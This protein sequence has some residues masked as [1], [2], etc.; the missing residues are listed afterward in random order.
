VGTA[1]IGYDH[2]D[3][4]YLRKKKI[5]FAS[6]PGSNANSVSEYITASLLLLAR[7][8]G[9]K[10][11]GSTIAVV[12]VGN[13]GSLVVKKAKTLGMNCLLNDP[14]KQ[15]QSRSGEYAPLKEAL[16]L[17]DYV[18]L[19]VPMQKKGKYATYQMAD[20]KFFLS[21]KKEASF[22]NSSRGEVVV[23]KDLKNALENGSLRDVVMDVWQNEPDIDPEMVEKTFIATPH[24]A[25]YSFDG[26]VN[27][28]LMMFNA[29]KKHLNSHAEFTVENLLPP[30]Y[31]PEI[32]LAEKK[33]ND[34]DILLD[35]ILEVYDIRRDD[36]EMRKAAAKEN[37]R[38]LEFD[39]LRKE[40]PRRREFQ[41][42][43]LFFNES[44]KALSQKAKGL[45]F[46]IKTK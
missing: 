25:G 41:Y 38:G 26:K 16:S 37:K 21:M 29:L 23:E 17:A 6:A 42:T 3:L 11:E 1:T 40:Y 30:P 33:G 5:V 4:N 34:E 13:V 20:K 36:R 7:Q 9:K 31:I 22:L 8:K 14:P 45:G 12:G 43:T 27:G 15:Q 28:T 24:I 10:L 32:D 46:K 35:A 39:R 44:Q 18:T 19:H 2:V